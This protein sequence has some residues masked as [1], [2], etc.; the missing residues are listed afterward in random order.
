MKYCRRPV[1]RSL[2]LAI[3][4]LIGVLPIL[5]DSTE[6]VS[7]QEVRKEAEKRFTM[8]FDKATW[9]KVIEWYADESGKPFVSRVA[10][11]AGTFSHSTPKGQTYTLHE[12]T[13]IIND[14][15]LMQGYVLVP[16]KQSTVLVEIK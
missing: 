1:C 2:L 11:P 13:I 9:Q 6:R 14:G 10:R 3:G 16:R 15:L 7:A 12:V 4:A 8:Q 5:G